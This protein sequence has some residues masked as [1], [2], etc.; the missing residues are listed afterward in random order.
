MSG[1]NKKAKV[2]KSELSRISKLAAASLNINSSLDLN[3]VLQAAV[4]GACELTGASFG[5]IAAIGE[6]VQFDNVVSFGISPEGLD[7]IRQ[8]SDRRGVFLHFRTFDKPMRLESLR[9]YVEEIGMAGDLLPRGPFLCAP[10]HYREEFI[11]NFYLA[12]KWGK[13]E[14]TD[15]DEE[16][17]RLFAAQAANAIANARAYREERR[18]RAD[19]E[20]LI[21]TTPVGVVV[22]DAKTGKISSINREG[23]R[24]ANSVVAGKDIVEAL[25]IL[26]FRR[27]DGT[28]IEFDKTPLLEHL[29]HAELIRAEELEFRNPDGA[30]ATILLNVTPIHS[31]KEVIE[32]VIVTMQDLAPLREL[33]K[34]RTEFV[35][36]VSHELR[37]PL[38]SIKGSTTALLDTSTK[39]DHAEMRE[40]FRIIDNQANSLAG[41]IRD[42]LDAGRI[43]TGTLAVAPESESLPELLEQ[44]RQTFTSNGNTQNLAVDLPP[45]AP[46]VHVDQRRIEQVLNNLLEN[47]AKHSPPKSTIRVKARTDGPHV[48]ISVTDEG[49]GL[50]PKQL[51][52]VFHKYAKSEDGQFEHEGLGLAICKGIVEAHG[53]RIWAQSD[54]IGRGATFTFTIPA[55][56]EENSERQP[57]FSE[58][59]SLADE[60]A[61]E[62]PIVL[63]VDDDPRALGSI[64]KV[65][66]SAGYKAVV[67]GDYR[68]LPELIQQHS[69]HLVLLDLVLPNMDGIELMSRTPQLAETPVIFVSAYGRDETVAKALESGAAD[70]I[71]KPFSATELTARIRAALRKRRDPIILELGSLTIDSDQRRAALNGRSLTLTGTEFELLRILAINAGRVLSYDYLINQVWNSSKNGDRRRVRTFI[72]K[73][74]RKLDRETDQPEVLIKNVRGV[75]YSLSPDQPDSQG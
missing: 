39:L 33:E 47:A 28:G 26:E 54:G 73:L 44:A 36:M 69:P 46:R 14:F 74:R 71:V 6:S 56:I 34:M 29:S 19:L 35:G 2:K 72:K 23:Q 16:I 4:E 1:S 75:G 43:E 18:A 60:T 27:G 22:F 62:A 70:Y 5:M 41:L 51:R 38:T 40:Y 10:M 31:T 20:A 61:K 58:N 15:E 52:R 9:S 12:S 65:L 53:G 67:T 42:L 45:N 37:A 8:W 63:V 13:P 49:R 55:E 59:T 25:K 24:I 30:S 7:Q 11:G 3:T 68:E 17:L 64:R 48:E 32:S 57:G 50:Q 66:T 21:E